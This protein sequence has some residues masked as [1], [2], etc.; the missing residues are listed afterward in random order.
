MVRRDA[1]E[2]PTRRRVGRSIARCASPEGGSPSPVSVGASGSR[3]QAPR[4]DPGVQ[5]GRQKPVRRREP[6]SG[7]QVRGPQHE[8]KP[9]ASTDKQ[10]ESR[11]AHVTAKATSGATVPK[12]AADLGGVEGAAHVQG[13][14]RH[15]RDPSARPRSGQGGTYKAKPKSCAVQRE[16]EGTVVPVMVAQNNARDHR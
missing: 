14:A 1:M 4:G 2:K 7:E 9:A 8:V 13:E 5:A 6:R 11:A 15:T 12:V 16:S 10:S 3:S